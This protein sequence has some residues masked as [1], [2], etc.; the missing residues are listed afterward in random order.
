MAQQTFLSELGDILTAIETKAKGARGQRRSSSKIGAAASSREGGSGADEAAYWKARFDELF[1]LKVTEPEKQLAL[2]QEHAAE[3]E[4]KAE[5]YIAHLRCCLSNEAV[6]NRLS[7]FCHRSD[8]ML[9]AP[10][11]PLTIF[12]LFHVLSVPRFLL[13]RQPPPS[14][15]RGRFPLTLDPFRRR[16]DVT[17]RLFSERIRY[18]T[19]DTQP[20]K[21][22]KRTKQSFFS[23]RCCFCRKN[24]HKVPEPVKGTP[25][26][27]GA[28][29][30]T[31]TAPTAAASA[32]TAAAATTATTGTQTE[33]AT[34]TAAATTAT[35]TT[36]TEAATSTAA[37]TTATTATQT[38]TAT[39]TAAATTATQTETATATAAE[40]P[41]S[42]ADRLA[43]PSAYV[44]SL[45]EKIE[46]HRR[47][48]RLYQTLSSLAIHPK[49][50]QEGGVE[51]DVMTC[52]AVNHVHRRAV[53]FDLKI[54]EDEESEDFAYHATGNIHLL[55]EYMRVSAI[56][57][58]VCF[59]LGGVDALRCFARKRDML[60]DPALRD[61]L[62][63][64][65]IVLI[66]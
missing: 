16:V 6:Q 25:A 27:P 56:S 51:G 14:R 38:E 57:S 60:D 43:A 35:T 22:V 5:Q 59:F 24:V 37:A 29:S 58:L 44:R 19:T 42:D 36:Q 50:G 3:K 32:A 20:C 2:I 62:P 45:E 30:A 49:E 61:A 40:E 28:S 53:R 47:V 7:R 41:E 18:N 9:P 66:D 48:I 54:P 33:A 10:E 65:L 63:L 34:A 1:A 26:T 55:P 52:T 23:E 15:I 12:F 21:A 4:R 13:S 17:R 46:H 31:S 64:L 8:I 39:S 11:Y